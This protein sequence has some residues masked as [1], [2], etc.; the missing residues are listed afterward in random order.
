[1]ERHGLLTDFIQRVKMLYFQIDKSGNAL[2]S[3][4][5]YEEIKKFVGNFGFGLPLE[6]LI[7]RDSLL[8]FGIARVSTHSWKEGHHPLEMDVPY[9]KIKVFDLPVFDPGGF[10]KKVVKLV[11]AT[12]QQI[13]IFKD[14]ITEFR[15]EILNYHI[16]KINA[17]FWNSL[18]EIDKQ[19]IKDYRQSLLDITDQE[20]FPW[21][22]FDEL[23]EI[24]IIQNK[25]LV[26]EFNHKLPW[27]LVYG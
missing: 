21:V 9:G 24:L 3:P 1:M 7:T 22:S 27:K 2:T 8:N 23:P 5:T 25:N 11:D 12:D 26:A 4:R 15:N 18:S 10:Y 19:T 14:K 16:D 20:G 17:V 6:E 13:Q